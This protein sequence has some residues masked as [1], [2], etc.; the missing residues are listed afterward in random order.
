MT[1]IADCDETFHGNVPTAK[2][3]RELDVSED[4]IDVL[5]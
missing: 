4:N 1:G 5:T 3:A 2:S